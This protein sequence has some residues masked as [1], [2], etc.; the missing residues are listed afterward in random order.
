MRLYILK[1]GAKSGAVENQASHKNTCVFGVLS[2]QGI[3]GL[4][5]YQFSPDA[6]SLLVWMSATI[7]FLPSRLGLMPSVIESF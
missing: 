7:Y 6:N 4:L 1:P 2:F 5:V 3:S